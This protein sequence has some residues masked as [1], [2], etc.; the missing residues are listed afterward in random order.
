MS[1][2]NQT[3][4]KGGMN[5]LLDDTRLNPTEYRLGFNLRNRYDVL[6]EVRVGKKNTSLPTGIV[7]E[8]VTFGTYIIAFVSGYAYYRLYTNTGWIKINSFK[9]SD[10][11]PR[12]WIE[13]VPLATTNYVRATPAADPLNGKAAI[14]QLNI[15]SGA[16]QGNLPGLLVQDNINQ[17][18]F[19]Y[20]DG[21]G[22]VQCRTTQNYEQWNVVYDTATGAMTTDQ[23]EYVPIGNAMAWVDG[24]LYVV[25]QDFNSIYRA[26]SG[27]PLDFVVNV[28][29][30]GTK[31][32]DATTTAYTV[33]VGGISCLRGTSDG[34]L[35][36]AASN[37]NFIVQKNM[38]VNAPTLFGEYTFIR[39]YLF[40]A[41][42]LNDR[43][44]IDS[45]G[46]TRFIDLTGVRSFNAIQQLQNEGRNSAFTANIAAA[47]KGIIQTTA[48]AILYDN[49]EMY[50]VNTVFGPAIAIYDTI[51]QC[52]TAF[53]T[54]QVDGKLIKKFAKIELGIQALFAVTEDNSV[55]E[56][57]AGAEYATAQ[58]WTLGIS[59]NVLNGNDNVKLNNAKI[60]V[61]PMEFRCILNN[62]TQDSTIS[63]TPFIDNR[64]SDVGTVEKFI[65]YVQP[66]TTYS[67]KVPS[68][69]TQLTNL[70]WMTPNSEQGWKVVFLVEWTGGG[71]IT[72]LSC[73][74]QDSTPMNPIRTQATTK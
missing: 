52:W 67:T 28:K 40:E 68:I 37:A 41:T 71:S 10:T 6:D 53:D 4:F 39:K 66:V 14:R 48:A 19:I 42:C 18:L 31:G 60:E 47:F 43:C 27:R 45:L 5:L 23:R 65:K 33:G 58:L 49:Y 38:S 35:F 44:I 73:K 13:A 25:S 61:K 12:Y 74:L 57:F 56:L 64:V 62:I 24:I 30:D 36:V 21:S 51:A 29:T 72:Q 55:Y 11:A 9:M 15:I 3:S 54:A 59:A 70:Y 17:P 50:A 34:S 8:L 69:N 46:D 7:Q 22:Q 20:I 2:Y 63:M 16:A 26:V 1:E 32:G